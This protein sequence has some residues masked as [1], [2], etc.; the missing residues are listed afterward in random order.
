M[1][2][3]YFMTTFIFTILFI[4]VLNP[5]SSKMGLIDHPCQRKQHLEPTPLTGG[6]AVYLAIFSTIFIY[7][8][9]IINHGIYILSATVLVCIGL[10]DDF[11]PIGFRIRMIT[12][13]CICILIIQVAN[14][15]IIDLGNLW[16]YGIFELG[17][18]ST[19]FTIF[20]LVGGINAFNMADGIDGLVGG[21]TL[22][23]VCIVASLAYYNDMNDLVNYCLI[24]ASA[25][26]AFLV[27]NLKLFGKFTPK[28]FLGDTGSTLLGFIVSALL[29]YISQGE[30]KI[31]SPV[32]VLWILAIPI[33]DSVSIMTRRISQGKSPFLPDRDHFHHILPL[34]GLSNKQ[35]LVVILASSLSLSIIGITASLIFHVPDNILFSI[36]LLLFVFHSIAMNK[37]KLHMKSN[38][39]NKQ[40]SNMVVVHQFVNNNI[41]P[42]HMIR[43]RRISNRRI[44]NIPIN[45]PDRRK[46]ERRKVILKL[47]VH[48]KM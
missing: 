14:I 12:Q 15:K 48:D 13:I 37:I 34:T 5:L 47:S 10:V 30:N 36:F 45:F 17:L 20:A 43:E 40:I 11:N 31:I 26:T 4:M 19:P 1:N 18:L 44:Y 2:P 29:I 41:N 35:T 16:S 24:L 27:F 32:T 33:I 21:L 8:L 39:N 28:I 7:D 9:N 6:L 38:I 3:T 25:I 22:I 23:V 42:Y 46:Q